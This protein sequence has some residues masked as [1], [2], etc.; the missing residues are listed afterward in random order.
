MSAT[1]Q[2]NRPPVVPAGASFAEQSSF[3]EAFYLKRYPDVARG[4][5]A[6]HWKSGWHHFTRAGQ[7]EG[8]EA[9]IAG[10][11]PTYYLRS[12]PI[13]RIEI[14][15][16]RAADA[17][18]HYQRFGKARAFLPNPMAPRPNNP[19][20][21]ASPFGG[22]WPDL[23]NAQDILAGKLEIG[24]VTEAQAVL[25]RQ[26]IE[27]GYVVLENAIPDAILDAAQEAL[28]MAYSGRLP[29]QL[30]ECGAVVKSRAATRWLKE[31]NDHPAK[32]LDIHFLSGAIRDIIFSD[33][34]SDFMALVFESRAMASQTLGFWLGS[35]QSGHQDTAYVAYT[36]PRN[37]VA[38]WIAL[39]DVTPGAGELFYN[40]RSHTLDDYLYMGKYKT[41]HD[42]RRMNNDV[43][44][45]AEV[46]AFVNSLK[47]R[48]AQQGMPKKPFIAK[49]GDVLIWHA[50]LVHGGNP[51]S[52]A[53][54][55]K[56]VVTHYCPSR[57]VPLY[58]ENRP[59]QIYNHGKHRFA[60]G[61]YT[62][63]EPGDM[64]G[65]AS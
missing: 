49:R 4:I 64:P 42:C 65:G 40:E 46:D 5:E 19:A 35:A 55:R 30:F 18:D 20:L 48:T 10:F 14:A 27:R 63:S 50:D 28:E 32:A 45:S 21:P 43:F 58:F 33:A 44:P 26:W 60:S 13:A 61:V 24:Q 2:T 15:E 62:H 7:R 3:D 34:I 54:T 53:T 22:L 56:S 11:D 25:L 8:R 23:P 52:K 39:E 38:S 57:L 31:F 47:N 12:Y 59:V 51:V 41:I 9:R 6:G 36:M 1:V 37:F 29:R 17:F 16:G